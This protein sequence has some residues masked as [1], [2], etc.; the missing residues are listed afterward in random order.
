MLTGLPATPTRRH[1]SRWL[2]LTCVMVGLTGCGQKGDL[3]LPPEPQD[4]SLTPI[5][6]ASITP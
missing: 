5:D 2:L 4:A 3:Y 1:L 6:Q